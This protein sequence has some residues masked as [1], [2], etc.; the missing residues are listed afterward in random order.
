MTV[1]FLIYT[2]NLKIEE[3][4]EI[5]SENYQNFSEKK[6]QIDP[7]TV[8]STG[9]NQTETRIQEV[10]EDVHFPLKKIYLTW[11]PS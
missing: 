5:C 11:H 10:N 3:T 6:R 2:L 9:P 8:G 1:I 7:D 4:R